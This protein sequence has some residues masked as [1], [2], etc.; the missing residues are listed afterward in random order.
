MTQ[1]E[2]VVVVVT[3]SYLVLVALLAGSFINLAADRLPRGESVVRPR[4]HC[5][6]CGRVLDVLDLIPV[7][8]YVVRGGRCASCGA[9][10]GFASPA[11]EALCG[12]AMLTSLLLLGPWVGAVAG[13]GAVV[14]I[15]VAVVGLGFGRLQRA[16]RGSRQG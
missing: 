3:N 12:A 1:V 14:L 16:T 11:V 2:I 9:S 7:G 6:T 13:L 5:R 8:G 15:G 10:I 4:S